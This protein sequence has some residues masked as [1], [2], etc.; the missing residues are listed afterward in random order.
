MTRGAIRGAVLG[1]GLFLP[2]AHAHLY[3]WATNNHIKKAFLL[4]EELGFDYKTNVVWAKERYGLG[5][6]FRGQHELLLF[7]V[8]GKGLHPSVM[9]ERRDLPTCIVADHVRDVRN[10][11]VHSAKPPE[12][13]DLIEARSRGP[14]IEFFARGEARKGWRVWGDQ[15]V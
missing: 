11:R 5:R 4:M 9:T 7:G 1:S 12:F 8:R 10:R 14:R 13:Y 3:M 15:A 6:Y 2:A